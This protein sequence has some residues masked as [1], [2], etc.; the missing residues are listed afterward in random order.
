MP[1]PP[2]LPLLALTLTSCTTDSDRGISGQYVSESTLGQVGPGSTQQNVLALLGD[3][4]TRAK[5]DAST[6]I[7]RWRYRES[8]TKNSHVLLLIHTA[9]SSEAEHSTF[10]QFENGLVTK[11]WRD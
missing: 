2:F 11:A 9:D 5:I 4:T 7:W 10:V 8:R 3:P 6:E 1:L